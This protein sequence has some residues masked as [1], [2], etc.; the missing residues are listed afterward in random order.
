MGDKMRVEDRLSTVHSKRVD[1]CKQVVN[2]WKHITN[3]KMSGI[4]CQ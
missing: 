1:G 2:E 3:D 4:T